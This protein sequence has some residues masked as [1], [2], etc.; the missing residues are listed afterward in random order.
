MRLSH[1]LCVLGLLGAFAARADFSGAMKD[2]SAGNF[3]A[4]HAQFLGLAELGDCFSQFNL[5]AMALKG[6]GVARDRGAG[7]G[8]LQAAASNGCAA[9]V[10][11]KLP[12]LVASLSPEQTAAAAA[13]IARY[14]HDRLKALG[15]VDPVFSC[16]DRSPAVASD[17][18]AP[19]Y[20]HL[21]G[22]RV[23]DAL[24]ITAL[25]VGADG[26]ARDPQVLLAVPATAF[27]AAA[28]EAWLNSRF[29]PALHA[30]APVDSLLIAKLRFAG[31][32]GELAQVPEFKQALPRAAAGDPAAEYLVGVTATVD[33]DLGIDRARAGQMLVDSA[34]AGNAD[35]QYFIG[36]QVRASAACHPLAD[37]QVW[38]QHAA[39]GGN[40]AAQV[41]VAAELL[42][43]S[44]SPGQVAEARALLLSAVARD[45]YFARLHA[46]ALLAA[47]P[48]SGVR[49]PQAALGGARLLLAG[50]IQSDP[51]MF[52][53]VAAAY[54]ANQR[55][56]DAVSQQ[57]AA[58]GKAWALGWKLDAMER[59]L[60]AY[61]ADSAWQGDLY[62]GR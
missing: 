39:A 55:F 36:M 59:R 52:E 50:E 60:A 21:K 43:G 19:D 49:D 17:T 8:W 29:R 26:R 45:D 42:R 44:P 3:E 46:V 6:Q 15:V 30:D 31:A 22:G 35:A 34:R 20:P 54:A 1:A 51:Q 16:P 27:P 9:Q 32:R 25:T 13:V 2:Y 10:G 61:R 28:V 37:G 23:A 58:L 18:P 56:G 11:D 47:S 40:P 14:G 24:V 57:R 48:V 38:L 7:V 4:A 12:G 5:G 62:A 33:S 53:G 41:D